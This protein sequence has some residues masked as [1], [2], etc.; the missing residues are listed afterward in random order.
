MVKRNS[1]IF[2]T[3][4]GLLL[5]GC[6][7]SGLEITKDDILEVARDD[8]NAT[9]SE[10]ENVS[11]KEQKGSYIVSFNTNGGSYEY[12]IGKDGIIKERSF[13][14]GAKEETTETEKVEEPVKEEKSK[15]SKKEEEKSSTSFDEGQQ[16]AINSALANSGLGQSDVSNITCSLDSNTNQYTVTFVLNDVTTTAV[17][18][19]ATF[20]VIS[21][22][23]G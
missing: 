3:A 13:K 1:L 23:L 11:I 6:S 8:A 9:K 10:C 16:Q 12:K 15:T 4:F 14:R 21:T 2:L 18:D 7:K 19:A 22:I 5:T 17:V 20:T